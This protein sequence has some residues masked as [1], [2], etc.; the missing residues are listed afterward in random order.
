MFNSH[1]RQS[2]KKLQG[3]LFLAVFN[4]KLYNY[5]VDVSN[6]FK[7]CKLLMILLLLFLIINIK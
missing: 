1:G 6:S 3:L 4:Y 7:N 5:K 2:K